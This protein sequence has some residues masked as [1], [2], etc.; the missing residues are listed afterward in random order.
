MGAGQRPKSDRRFSTGTSHPE[1]TAAAPA[2]QHGPVLPA[3]GRAE[4][5]TVALGDA[6]RLSFMIAPRGRGSFKG[7]AKEVFS[8][9]QD[10]VRRQS[11]PMKLTSATIFL[12]DAAAKSDCAALLREFWGPDV[13]VTNFVLQAP[14]C[15]AALAVEAWA[16]QAD[17]VSMRRF[18]SNVLVLEYDGVQWLHCGGI[19]VPGGEG[20]V[21][22]QTLN[23]LE[24]VRAALASAGFNFT[25]VVRTWFYLGNIT[26]READTER[27]RELNRA[28]T[29]YYRSIGFFESLLK[30]GAPRGAYPAST[31]IGASD[32]G[33]LIACTA[34]RS[35]HDDS[36]VLPLENPRQTPA[37]AYHPKYSAQSPKFSRALA[38]LRPNY[39][40]TWI[41]G[42][43]SI[44]NSESRHPGDVE[45]Q[46]QQTL[47]NIERLIAADNF[48]SR[49]VKGAGATLKDLAKVRVYIKR[50]EDYARCKAVCEKRFGPIPAIYAVADVCRP[51][52]LVEIEGIAF[53]RRSRVSSES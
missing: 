2:V 9:I 11:C 52:L 40:V 29:D 6:S 26:G 46:T 1:H 19:E 8:A 33:L 14:C 45:K 50:H 15:G 17:A 16:V 21:Y 41:S 49:G 48:A 13:P 36:Y 3:K 20:S 22:A 39:T 37:Y 4:F 42:T 23:G 27:Y 47:D 7:Q 43:A 5:S 28:R 38:L 25:D 12:Q 51:E 32:S 31:G 35:T 53:S 30:P 34:F 44:V 18:G 10:I 24:Q